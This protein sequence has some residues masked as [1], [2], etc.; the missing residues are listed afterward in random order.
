M[1]RPTTCP[2]LRQVDGFLQLLGFQLVHKVPPN[3][4]TQP[5]LGCHVPSHAFSHLSTHVVTTMQQ[6]RMVLVALVAVAGSISALQKLQCSCV[7]SSRPQGNVQWHVVQ[8]GC[9]VS[10][11]PD[12]PRRGQAERTLPGRVHGG[13]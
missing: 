13:R 3:A 11:L 12:H 9:H 8:H 5:G 6:G 1:Y 4:R 2:C 10:K 7:A